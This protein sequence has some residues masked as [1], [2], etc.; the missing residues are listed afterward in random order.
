[1]TPRSGT[2]YDEGFSKKWKIIFAVLIGAIV[3]VAIFAEIGFLGPLPNNTPANN[4]PSSNYNNGNGN[5]ALPKVVLTVEGSVTKGDWIRDASTDLPDYESTVSYS[6]S[7]SGNLD[8]S[9]VSI[10]ISIDGTHYSSNVIPLIAMSDSYSSSF[11]YS[12]PYDQTSNVLIAAN[13]QGSSDSYTLSIGSSFPRSWYVEGATPTVEL[14][15]TPRE[16][17][18][19][20]MKDNILKNKFFLNPDWIAIREWVGNNIKY[21]YAAYETSTCHW[22]FPKETLQSGTGV[23]I[24]YSILL[25]SLYRDGVFSAN[26]VYVV[27]GM[28][29][30]EGHAWVKVNLP[31]LGWYTLEPQING[32][33]WIAILGDLVTVSGYHAVYEFNDQQFRTIG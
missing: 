8:A 22:Q 11:S 23:C 19:A 28:S 29:G 2:K 7:D 1:M 21:N 17:N 16:Q 9:S 33:G 14:F 5:T 20:T 32:S 26:D 4:I 30:T 15:I 10:T 13:C 18:L 24:D 27:V 25:C 6:V 31:V 12:I 3:V